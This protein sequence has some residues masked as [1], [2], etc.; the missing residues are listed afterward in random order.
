MR[1]ALAVVSDGKPGARLTLDGAIERDIGPS[2]VTFCHSHFYRP[3]MG[4]QHH[5]YIYCLRSIQD[6]KDRKWRKQYGR[7]TAL[8]SSRDATQKPTRW[9]SRTYN[10][11]RIHGTRTNQSSEIFSC[12]N[13]IGTKFSRS[14]DRARSSGSQCGGTS[15]RIRSGR[16]ESSAGITRIASVLATSAATSQK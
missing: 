2:M 9:P 13:G 12:S 15:C 8:S 4:R 16:T 10:R 6:K 3:R 5:V 11:R 7:K 1:R 14:I